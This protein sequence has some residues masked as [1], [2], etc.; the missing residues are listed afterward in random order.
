MPSLRGG[1]GGFHLGIVTVLSYFDEV[2]FSYKA[3]YAL[4]LGF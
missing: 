3:L 1:G 4:K 2:F